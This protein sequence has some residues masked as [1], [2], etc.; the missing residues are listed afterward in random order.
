MTD[1]KSIITANAML[2]GKG[3]EALSELLFGEE[4]KIL[5]R[6]ENRVLC[7]SLWDNYQGYVD[8]NCL[9]DTLGELQDIKVVSCPVF[10]EADLKSKHMCTL[11]LN[12]KIKIHSPPPALDKDEMKFVKTDL[13]WIYKKH[14]N[15]ACTSP[16]QL[17]KYFIGTPYIWGGKSCFGIDCSAMVQMVYRAFGTHL[18][19]DSTM[20]QKTANAQTINRSDLLKENDLVFWMGHVGIML[21]ADHVI[22]AN[23]TDMFVNQQNLQRVEKSIIDNKGGEILQILRLNNG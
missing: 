6:S 19:R 17:A 15:L 16:A 11:S 20:Q 12:S 3:G 23:A 14:L 13:G 8:P 18:E 4:V 10:A 2:R 1:N 7:E 22:H 9:G 21:N 5:E